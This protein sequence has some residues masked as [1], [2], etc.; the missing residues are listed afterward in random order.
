MFAGERDV[1]H[2]TILYAYQL[3]SIY[4]NIIIS[5]RMKITYIYIALVIAIIVGL[6]FLRQYSNNPRAEVVTK[7]D[8][9][10]ECLANAGAQFYG[11]YWCPHCQDQKKM[12]NNS[13]KLPY[14]E[15]STPNG[16][17]RTQVCIDA[18]V[19]SYPTWIFADG[20]RLDGVKQ[21][22]ELGEKTSCE[23]PAT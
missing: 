20:S 11:A 8:A 23:V 16:Q 21:L 9:F 1:D 7:F 15:C 3:E 12:F 6:I 14:I 2:G 4:L 13:K 5:T 22:A 19:E 10:A 17:G 18:N